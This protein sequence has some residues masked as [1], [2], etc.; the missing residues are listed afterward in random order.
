MESKLAFLKQRKKQ[1]FIRA[2]IGG[3][4]ASGKSTIG[5]RL[6]ESLHFGP[7]AYLD[8]EGSARFYKDKLAAGSEYVDM[9]DLIE[10]K[11]IIGQLSALGDRGAANFPFKTIVIDTWYSLWKRFNKTFDEKN[12]K[13][14]QLKHEADLYNEKKKSVKVWGDVKS[15][16]TKMILDILYLPANIVWLTWQTGVL[17]KYGAPVDGKF[18]PRYDTLTEHMSDIILRITDSRKFEIFRDRSET[19]VSGKSSASVETLEKAL[20][21]L[22]GDAKAQASKPEPAAEPKPQPT[23]QPQQQGKPSTGTIKCE[24]CGT[25]ISEVIA[26]A[27]AA[28]SGGKSLCP[29]CLKKA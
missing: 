29:K 22:N 2:V 6:S 5:V 18:E 25:E 14:I 4:P 24:D 20:I 17:N 8:I 10:A 26:K 15:P 23:T 12:D 21:K 27:T 19:M 16:F 9:Q 13:G 3:G 28:Q 7:I 1:S 11:D